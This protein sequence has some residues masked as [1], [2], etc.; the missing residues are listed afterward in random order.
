MAIYGGELFIPDSMNRRIVVLSLTGT[1]LRTIENP[2]G[3]LRDV[4]LDIEAHIWTPRRISIT[5]EGL[6]LVTEEACRD[7]GE[8]F[9]NEVL[10]MTRWGTLV[11]YLGVPDDAASTN[12]GCERLVDI[13]VRGEQCYATGYVGEPVENGDVL[14]GVA[15]RPLED[16]YEAR[17][18]CGWMHPQ[19]GWVG[20]DVADIF[21]M[22]VPRVFVFRLRSG[23]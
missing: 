8:D 11:S 23:A 1:L 13:T 2:E 9:G 12:W 5:P 16:G 20:P 15:W 14:R 19:F 21:A 6:L 10:L 4:A 22:Q 18:R 3:M 17:C 7:R